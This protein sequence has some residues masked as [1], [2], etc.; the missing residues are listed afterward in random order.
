MKYFYIVIVLGLLAG[1]GKKA[2]YGFIYDYETKKP[3]PDVEVNDY[4]NGVK[5]RSDNKGYFHLKHKGNISGELIFK[6]Q[7]YDIDTLKTTRISNGEFFKE[8]FKGDTV[9]MFNV[10]SNFKDSIAKLNGVKIK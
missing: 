6:K 5:T 7:G 10:N 1:C 9:Y 3:L 8:E 4:L 2:Y